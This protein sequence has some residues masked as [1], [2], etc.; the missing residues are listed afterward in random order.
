MYFYTQRWFTGSIFLI[1]YTS[2]NENH[3][4]PDKTGLSFEPFQNYPNLKFSQESNNIN[5]YTH[6]LTPSKVG[7]WLTAFGYSKL[8]N[9]QMKIRKN[10][11]MK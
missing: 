3:L 8:I 9:Y 6:S 10:V 7:T 2:G 4:I 1:L 5:N 11:L